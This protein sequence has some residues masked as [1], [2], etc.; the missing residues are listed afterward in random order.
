MNAPVNPTQ[1][2]EL[3]A[4]LRPHLP[5]ELLALVGANLT[6]LEWSELRVRVLEEKLR[7]KRIAKY[8]PGSEKLS[9]AQ[10]ELLELEP[11]VSADEIAAEAARGPLPEPP[12]TARP[13]RQK[14]PHPGRQDFPENLPRI[15]TTLSCGA[16]QQVCA[17]CGQG[18]VVVGF[19]QS[20]RLD[21]KP[22]EYIV[23]VTKREKRACRR[24]PAA[25]V[26]A[27]PLPPTIIDKGLAS[28]AVVINVLVA[29]YADHMPLYRQSAQLARDA[30]VEI[31]RATLDGWVMQVGESLGPLVACMAA[32]LK[33]GRYLQADETPVWV[34]T[35]TGRHHHQAYLW[36]YGRPGA[37]VV[38]DFRM[39]RERAGPL[40]WLGPW[41]GILQTDG[42]AAYEGVGGPKLVNLGC[43][44]H[45][46]RKFVDVLKLQPDHL[47]SIAVV[48]DINALF[49]LDREAREQGFDHARRHQLRQAEAPALLAAIRQAVERLQAEALPGTALAKAV[50]YLL[51]QWPKLIRFLDHPE[52]EL[53]NNVAENSMRP[54]AVGRKNWIHVGSPA[55][56]PKVA[57]ILS[58]FETCRR[59]RIPLRPYLAAVLPSLADTPVS[60]LAALTPAAWAAAKQ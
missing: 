22:A 44:S 3:L 34:Q 2:E 27:A 50:H 6:R 12:T 53:S 35:E 26:Q 8:G 1:R 48:A 37:G 5:E 14:R 7:L 55:A 38:F 20:E 49:A 40:Q 36:Q 56:G 39:G 57:A 19:D 30:G 58:V 28:D 24:C 17:G 46:R 21:V 52:A 11:G 29:K 42:Y 54:L 10:L 51:A 31:S 13:Q 16:A 4:Q 25:G 45:G 18:T 33:A 23:R 32:E 43:W 41:N 59:M 9:A 15:E 60:R 47:G